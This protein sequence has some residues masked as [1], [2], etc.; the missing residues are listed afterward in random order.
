MIPIDD[1]KL[2]ISCCNHKGALYLVQFKHQEYEIK[3]V[4]NVGAQV[5]QN[6]AALL[7]YFQIL[8]E[9]LF[10]MKT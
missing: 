6:T 9:S 8:M 2:L 1:C 7:S 3:K 5:L 4:L 10:W